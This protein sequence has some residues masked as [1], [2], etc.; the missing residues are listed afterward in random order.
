MLPAMNQIAAIQMT[1]SDQLE[2]NLKTAAQLLGVAQSAGSKVAVLPENFAW[3]GADDA[4]D[5]YAEN[6]GS[7][8]V[9]DFLAATAKALQL[10]II[11]G[12]FRMKCDDGSR[13]TNTMLVFDDQG[14]QRARYD[15]IHLFDAALSDAESYKESNTIAA[16]DQLVVVDTPLGKI[17]LSIC[18]DLRFAYLYQQ[19]RDLGA[20][21][22]VIP[23]AFTVP[24]GAAHWEVLVRA[25]AIETQCYI[26]APG[27]Q[28]VHPSGRTTWGQTLITDPWGTKLAEKRSEEGVI[29]AEIDLASLHALR[30]RMPVVQ[31]R[32]D[33]LRWSA[34]K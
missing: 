18:Y 9:Q 20:E 10:W 24:T 5:A 32:R 26:V 33:N 3:M 19:L 31:H 12:S 1:S 17:G 16:G 28:G 29:T 2:Q 8:P 22:I 30:Q 4:T 13:C 11:G 34:I 21:I 27:Q 6:F 25:R 7:G 14:E 15:K 23:S